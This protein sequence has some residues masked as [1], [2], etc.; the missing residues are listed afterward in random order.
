MPFVDQRWLGG[1][2]T[3]FKTVKAVAQAAQGHA[4]H[5]RRPALEATIKKEALLFDRELSKLE[6]DIGGIQD[7]NALPDAHVRRRRRLPQD[8]G[9]RG[10]QAGH[11]R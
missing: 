1:M 6:K 11:S 9:G 2:L 7:M 4:G 5:A 8:R 10:Q 3:N